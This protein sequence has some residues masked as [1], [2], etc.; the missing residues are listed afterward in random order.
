MAFIDLVFAAIDF[1]ISLIPGNIAVDPAF[2]EILPGLIVFRATIRHV[3][4]RR[5]QRFLEKAAAERISKY[6]AHVI[7][8]I[9]CMPIFPDCF[10]SGKMFAADIGVVINEFAFLIPEIV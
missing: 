10:L 1:F 6:P 7:H 8:G 4:I 2:I 3:H 5:A 9:Y